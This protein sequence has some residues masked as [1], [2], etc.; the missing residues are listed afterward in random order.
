MGVNHLGV[1]LSYEDLMRMVREIATSTI[2]NAAI[3]RAGLTVY[4][5]GWI[6]IENGGL[7]VTGQASVSGSLIGS[8]TFLWTGPVNI[9]GNTYVSGTL[10]VVGPTAFGNTVTITGATT[11]G[12]TT[13]IAGATTISGATLLN[14]DLT[15]GSGRILCGAVTIS[16]TGGGQV[17]V[18]NVSITGGGSSGGQVYSASQLELRGESGVRVI[19]KL[20]TSEIVALGKVTVAGDLV[21]ATLDVA[22][23]KNFRMPH[24]LK[25]RH[26]L[27]HGSTESPIS[28]T[29]YTGRASLDGTGQAVIMLPDYFEAL[30]KPGGRT[31]HV[32]PVG[33]PFPVGADEVQGGQVT[34]YGEPGRDVYWLVKAERF[35]G[36][37]PVEEEIEEE[38]A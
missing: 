11:I 12:G 27:R 34:V 8:G 9:A 28:G 4:G 5:G 35:G 31:V 25:P 20:S 36:D 10:N 3:G 22:G 33:R 16:Q 37:F 19:G 13:T 17:S 18:G 23:A 2:Q 15:V 6:T 24:P 38:A 29:E 26:W 30:N 1:P 7:S 32:T 21:A 14:A